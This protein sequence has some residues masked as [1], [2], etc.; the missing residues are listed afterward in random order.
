MKINK[1][2]KLSINWDGKEHELT[3]NASD[4][5]HTV[6]RERFWVYF[7]IGNDHFW[8][9]DTLDDCDCPIIE[10]PGVWRAVDEGHDEYYTIESGLFSIIEVA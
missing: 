4:F 6:P 2:L 3:L 7:D 8:F 9:E 1:Y 5:D 10:L